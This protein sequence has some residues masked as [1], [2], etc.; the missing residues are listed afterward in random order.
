[1]S[2][3]ANNEQDNNDDL[4]RFVHGTTIHLWSGNDV[5]GIGRGDFGAGFYTFEDNSWGRKAAEKWARRKAA[6]FDRGGAVR[7]LPSGIPIRVEPILVHVNL[8]LNTL[9]SLRRRDVA[10]ADLDVTYRTYYPDQLMGY[11]LIVG[12]VGKND[13]HGVRVPNYEF[14]PQYK[15]EGDIIGKL[16]ISRASLVS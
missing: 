11:E 10:D 5:R 12:R 7:L 4:V 1:M 14:P 6:G 2:A 8:R 9:Q 13:A 3:I 16:V 15:F